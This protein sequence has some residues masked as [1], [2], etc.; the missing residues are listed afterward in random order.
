MKTE[1]SAGI[2]IYRKT[3]E[4]PKFL[5]LYHGGPYWNFPK[6]KLDGES[7]FKAALREVHEETGI[8]ERDLRFR[9]WFKVQD[10]FSYTRNKERINK[11]VTY[12]L[13]ETKRQEIKIKIVPEAHDG[14]KHEGY[15]WL[16]YRDASRFLISPTLKLN[17]KKAYATVIQRKNPSSSKEGATRQSN[18]IQRN[19]PFSR[20]RARISSSRERAAQ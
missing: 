6:G 10:R 19:R 4:G 11:T 1:H 7:N 17:L 15:A 18:N 8:L 14:E 13:A 2:I 16:L 12:Y 20:E 5:L 9:T 3:K